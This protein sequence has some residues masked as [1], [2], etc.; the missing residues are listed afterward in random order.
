MRMPIN[1]PLL[2]VPLHAS[3]SIGN[4]DGSPIIPDNNRHK[5]KKTKTFG[6]VSCRHVPDRVVRFAHNPVLQKDQPPRRLHTEYRRLHAQNR[7]LYA[8]YMPL[9]VQCTM[10]MSLYIDWA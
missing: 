4:A 10:T 7:R 1:S 3:K 8:Q 6:L 9:Q 2:L 5:H